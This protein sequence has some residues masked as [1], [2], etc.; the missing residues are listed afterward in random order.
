MFK[1]PQ[2]A[3]FI[4]LHYPGGNV[5]AGQMKCNAKR[6]ISSV[7]SVTFLCIASTTQAIHSTK[8][9]PDSPEAVFSTI[10]HFSFFILHYLKP[11]LYCRIVSMH[12]PETDSL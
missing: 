5:T 11:H 2:E 8:Q 4:T 12:L 1:P 9:L 6:D 10:L 7:P 3:F